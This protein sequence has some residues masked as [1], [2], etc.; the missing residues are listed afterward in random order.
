VLTRPARDRLRWTHRVRSFVCLSVLLCV[1]CPASAG[2]EEYRGEGVYYALGGQAAAGGPPGWSSLP[3]HKE[4]SEA[5][6]DN[7][8]KVLGFTIEA[9]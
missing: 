9:E 2:A 3:W 7:G 8:K 5:K 6:K 1:V 4:A